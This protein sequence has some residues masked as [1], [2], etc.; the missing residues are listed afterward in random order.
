MESKD[1]WTLMGALYTIHK[2]QGSTFGDLMKFMGIVG[3]TE[4]MS[5]CRVLKALRKGVKTGMILKNGPFYHFNPSRT[6]NDDLSR[7]SSLCLGF[8][9]QESMDDLFAHNHHLKSNLRIN[10]QLRPP[11]RNA[12]KKRRLM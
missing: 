10:P 6:K 9:M 8:P 12:T 11:V 7:C 1:E 4:E 2:P 3:R 5:K